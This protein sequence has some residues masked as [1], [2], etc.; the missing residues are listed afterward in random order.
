MRSYL[1]K[2]YIE[3]HSLGLLLLL[4]GCF[5]SSS[6]TANAQ[7][8]YEIQVCGADTVAPKNLMVEF[9]SNYTVSGL[10]ERTGWAW[11]F[12]GWETTF[13]HA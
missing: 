2:A 9:H 8:N 3:P 13:A 12:S 7:G 11:K 5:L 10:H 4:T 6:R 1:R